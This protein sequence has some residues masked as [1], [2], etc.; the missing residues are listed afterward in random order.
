M[1]SYGIVSQLTPP[2]TPQHNGVSGKRNRTLLDMVRSMMNLTT[3][4]KSFWRYA[5]ESAARILNMVLTKKVERT[6]HKIWHKK[7][8]KLSY[9][10]VWGSS[11]EAVWMRKFIDGLGN[12][13]PSNK[14]PMEMLCDNEP[15]IAIANVPRILKRA[16]HYK[17]KYHYIRE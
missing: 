6:P 11:M 15:A 12:V 4:P 9:L 2:Y 7:A 5:L 3:L 8:P 16:R 13:M 17:R 1:K 14:R 10:R